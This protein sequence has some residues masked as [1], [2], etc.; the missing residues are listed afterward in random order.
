MGWKR[1][2]WPEWTII[3]DLGSGAAG[4]VFKIRRQDIGGTY[5]AAL[6]V[7]T[8]P[9]TRQQIDQLRSQNMTD[10]QISEYF[11]Q[12]VSD[13]SREISVMER[14]KGNSNIVSYEDHKIVQHTNG[15]GWDVMIRMELLTSLPEY[16]EKHTIDEKEICKLG[17]DICRALTLCEKEKIIHRD[18][19]PGNIFISDFG[20]F[21]LGD[22]SLVK[23]FEFIA[24]L[25]SPKGTYSYMA[26]EVCQGGF[27]DYSVDIYG[28][29]L[30]LY[31]LLN[32]GRGPFQPLPP[33]GITPE[34][35]EEANRRRLLAEMLPKPADASPKMAAIIQ[36][37]CAKKP[38]KRFQNA[39]QMQEALLT[40]LSSNPDSGR[41]MPVTQY[42][43]KALTVFQD[44]DEKS[45]RIEQENEGMTE[46]TS[47]IIEK[48][49]KK[50][51]LRKKTM[52]DFFTRAGDL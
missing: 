50:E 35:S 34:I 12:M 27:F 10:S 38:E 17:V 36:K 32:R 24:E 18:V 6:K 2:L 31:R 37:A 30:V 3:S 23:N 13:I 9:Q 28:L 20:D 39:Q 47:E 14:L 8:M 29:G 41:R 15:F 43:K 21:K 45:F 46:K 22:F 4:K 11:Q 49:E 26:P 40:C 44:S 51:P 48:I 19:K 33:K 16:L 52:S 25:S 5:Y 1:E 7:I 42:L